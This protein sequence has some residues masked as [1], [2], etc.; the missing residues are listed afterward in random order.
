MNVSDRINIVSSPSLQRGVNSD[1]K[2]LKESPTSNLKVSDRIS[3]VSPMTKNEKFENA[4]KGGFKKFHFI[5][6]GG[7]SLRGEEQLERKG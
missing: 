2:P 4:L 1:T 6:K 7:R 3:M 5:H